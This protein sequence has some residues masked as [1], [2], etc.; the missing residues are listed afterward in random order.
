MDGVPYFSGQLITPEH[1]LYESHRWGSNKRFDLKPRLIAMCRQ[2]S[3]VVAVVRWA[4]REGRELRIRSSGSCYAASSLGQDVVLDVSGLRSLELRG[5]ELIAGAGATT[6][7]IETFLDGQGRMAVL[8][9]GEGVASAGFC[10]G[11]GYSLYSRHYGLGADQLL[12]ARL[13][14]YQGR[15]IETSSTHHQDLF[16]ALQGAGAANFG[17]VTSLRLQTHPVPPIVTVY[18]FRWSPDKATEVADL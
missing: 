17:V 6:A 15:L 16:W 7:D 9:T 11:G 12:A 14:D 3:D 13:V 10:L 8:G 18:N 5:T 2:E 4:Y 1:E